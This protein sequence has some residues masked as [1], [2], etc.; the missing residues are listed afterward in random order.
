MFTLLTAASTRGGAAVAGGWAAARLALGTCGAVRGWVAAPAA[1][2][3]AAWREVAFG[4]GPAATV[5]GPVGLS[6][7]LPGQVACPPAPGPS[8]AAELTTP[9]FLVSRCGVGGAG[10]MGT[11]SPGRTGVLSARSREAGR[12]APH[13]SRGLGPDRG[14]APA[15]ALRLAPVPA[16]VAS[17]TKK[18]RAHGGGGGGGNRS[19]VSGPK[20]LE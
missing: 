14:Q 1:S 12:G 16:A 18:L 17:V 6:A 9:R 11:A 7:A 4:S 8:R 19:S 20:E 2:A 10:R 15:E 13:L 5:L 3:G